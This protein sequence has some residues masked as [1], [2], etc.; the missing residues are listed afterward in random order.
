VTR[1]NGGNEEIRTHRTAIFDPLC[2]CF[3]VFQDAQKADAL[4]VCVHLYSSEIIDVAARFAA[5]AS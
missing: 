4:F 2:F 5:T 3:E 1:V